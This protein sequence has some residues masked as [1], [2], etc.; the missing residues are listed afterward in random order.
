MSNHSSQNTFNRPFL[1]GQTSYKPSRNEILHGQR[2]LNVA[3]A[4]KKKRKL[5]CTKEMGLQKANDKLAVSFFAQ[6]FDGVMV[7]VVK[8]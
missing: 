5:V 2:L 4:E 7:T 6:C 1:Q 8:T 3:C